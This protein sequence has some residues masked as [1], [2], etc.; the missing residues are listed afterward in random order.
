MFKRLDIV[1]APD[2]RTGV[3]I[4]PSSRKGVGV[5]FGADGPIEH[6]NRG[7]LCFG[8]SE[9]LPGNNFFEKN[10]SGRES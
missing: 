4:N 10:T 8:V 6:F 9:D 2:G 7:V 5:K 1:T 3:V